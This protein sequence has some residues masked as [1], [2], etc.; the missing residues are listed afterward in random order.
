MINVGEI[1]GTG[2]EGTLRCTSRDESQSVV[3]RQVDCNRRAQSAVPVP[4]L[5]CRHSSNATT[6]E[7]PKTLEELYCF[8]EWPFFPRVHETWMN[9]FPHY[10]S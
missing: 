5:S 1:L 10:S 9:P 8:L 6:F 3:V 2:C 4:Y 7:I